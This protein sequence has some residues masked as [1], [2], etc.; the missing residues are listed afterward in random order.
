MFAYLL[1]KIN[2]FINC[3]FGTNHRGWKKKTSLTAKIKTADQIKIIP[4]TLKKKILPS[5]DCV[6]VVIRLPRRYLRSPLLRT[7]TKVRQRNRES[8]HRVIVMKSR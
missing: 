1:F 7:D 5:K 4:S 6:P 2:D 8:I 3:K